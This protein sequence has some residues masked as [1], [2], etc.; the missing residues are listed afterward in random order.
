MSE[1][2]YR[3]V[4]R[5]GK[6]VRR[7][8]GSHTYGYTCGS[9]DQQIREARRQHYRLLARIVVCGDKI[10]GIIIDIREHFFAQTCQAYLCI[11]HSGSAG[12]VNITEVAVAVYQ[13]VAHRPVLGKA[14]HRSVYGRVSVGVIFTHNLAHAVG[15]FLMGFVIRVAHCVHT[16][17]DATLDG[18]E[19]VTS[20]RQS[21]RHYYRHRV[22]DVGRFHLVLDVN[23][24]YVIVFEHAC[25]YDYLIIYQ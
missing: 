16:I 6:V 23:L 18:F 7:H 19:A 25:L 21:T 13:G 20:I 17:K 4:D 10:Y 24:Y 15:R 12:S 5:L 14:Y 9:V 2:R 8:I 11:T 1:Q 3:C 22:V